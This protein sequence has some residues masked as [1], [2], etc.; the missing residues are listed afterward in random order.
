[1]DGIRVLVP[2]AVVAGQ[3]KTAKVGE[4]GDWLVT[5]D[6]M[7]ASPKGQALQVSGLR[8][9][10]SVKDVLV[11]DVCKDDGGPYVKIDTTIDALHADEHH[12]P[13]TDGCDGFAVDP[14][15]RLGDTL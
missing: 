5:L 8:S 6:P 12:E 14:D 2:S 15:P 7:K 13:G 4:D 3:K 9:Q 1:M 11:G 10:V